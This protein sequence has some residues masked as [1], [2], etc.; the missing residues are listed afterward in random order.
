MSGH[1][2]GLRT[3]QLYCAWC[4]TTPGGQ[5]ML[6]THAH[7]LDTDRS[8]RMRCSRSRRPCCWNASYI[9]HFRLHQP[10]HAQVWKVSS[11]RKPLIPNNNV[12]RFWQHQ[13]ATHGKPAPKL[14]SRF[15]Y[16]RVVLNSS[17]SQ[18][19]QERA[20][21]T[22]K[23]GSQAFANLMGALPRPR[24]SLV[25]PSR[26]LAHPGGFDSID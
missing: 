6:C 16:L 10:R 4:K 24:V 9:H 14:D 12:L 2:N 15:A 26:R 22:P 19:R 1:P 17:T 13:P 21:C 3:L 11:S 7:R 18:E 8:K 5:K 20:L 23:S 25:N